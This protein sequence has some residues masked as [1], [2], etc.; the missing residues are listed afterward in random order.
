[1]KILIFFLLI[2]TQGF[3]QPQ[4]IKLNLYRINAL[5]SS[6]KVQV[7]VND[8]FITDIKNTEKIELKFKK[9][10]MIKLIIAGENPKFLYEYAFKLKKDGIYN[11]NVKPRIPSAKGFKLKVMDASLYEYEYHEKSFSID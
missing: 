11:Y 10:Q 9:E 4:N 7:Y 5:C 6:C 3:T 1:M 8:Q 2:T